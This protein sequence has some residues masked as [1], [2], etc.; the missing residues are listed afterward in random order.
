MHE[1]F[2]AGGAATVVF[3][4]CMC[5][6]PHWNEGGHGAI[7]RRTTGS[8]KLCGRTNPTLYGLELRRLS[9]PQCVRHRF[10]SCEVL[11]IY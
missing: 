11:Y 9:H 5:G 3:W 1:H 4:A 6:W 8:F 2:E 7:F 10:G